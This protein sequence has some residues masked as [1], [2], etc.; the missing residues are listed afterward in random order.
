[1]EL[2]KKIFL[3][4]GAWLPLLSS[5]NSSVE[6]ALESHFPNCRQ[7]KEYL[8]LTKEQVSEMMKISEVESESPVLIR[9]RLSCHDPQK[10]AISYLESHNV[11][12]QNETLLV[13]INPDGS[14][15]GVEVVS[16]AEPP[17]YKPDPSWVAL[18]AHRK[19]SPELTLKRAIPVISGATLSARAVTSS[20]RRLLALHSILEKKL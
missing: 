11:R 15:R 8:Y 5:A 13:M 2:L 12:T 6:M 19:F 10:N 16:F 7:E 9:F 17:E 3:L 1:M 4:G 18:F 20:V 14:V